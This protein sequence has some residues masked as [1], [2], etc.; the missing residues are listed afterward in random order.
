MLRQFSLAHGLQSRCPSSGWCSINPNLE[1]LGKL[2]R[3]PQP[4][5]ARLYQFRSLEPHRS[6]Q[7]GSG[8]VGHHSRCGCLCADG[9]D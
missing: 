8:S 5:N 4:S 6:S 9:G 2:V 7:R 3:R 1:G